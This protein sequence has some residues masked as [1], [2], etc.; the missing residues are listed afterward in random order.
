MYKLVLFILAVTAITSCSKTEFPSEEEA[1]KTILSW[2]SD[3]DYFFIKSIPYVAHGQEHYYSLS[4]P[5]DY[6]DRS[7]IPLFVY[8]H[9]NGGNENSEINVLSAYIWHAL[10]ACGKDRPI[11]LFPGNVNNLYVLDENFHIANGIISK[12]E[13]SYSIAKPNRRVIMGFSSGGAAATRTAL[14]NPESFILSIS[15][16]GGV[17]P[18]DEV[19]FDSVVNNKGE[20]ISRNFHAIIF[21]GEKDNPDS[22]SPLLRVMNSSMIPYTVTI[23]KDQRHN[24]AQYLVRTQDQF[25]KLI[26]SI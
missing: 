9:G 23:L 7:D 19:L 24:L 11:I 21:K 12:L 5:T 3:E 18:K 17:W 16:A 2:A 6:K 8:L 22:Y 25:E 26:C 4:L 15:W 13:E 1:N 14:V 20:L 10:R